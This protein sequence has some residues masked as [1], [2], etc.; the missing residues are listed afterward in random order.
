MT[1]KI[2]WI[3]DKI[4]DNDIVK[5]LKCCI[6]DGDRCDICPLN[7]KCQSNPFVPFN[8]MYA[9]DLINRK[10]TQIKELEVELKAMRGAANSY[11]LENERLLQKLQQAKS[12]AKKEFAEKIKQR[13]R[14]MKY[15]LFPE[16]AVSVKDIDDVVKETVGIAC[17]GKR[18]RTACRVD[19]VCFKFIRPEH[20]SVLTA[21]T[22]NRMRNM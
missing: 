22:M 1:D 7:K 19:V 17:F 20:G 11:K 12:E 10:D 18:K 5:S 16:Y 9:L 15:D 6:D 8:I 2:N 21:E 14:I 4:K 3:E 13:E